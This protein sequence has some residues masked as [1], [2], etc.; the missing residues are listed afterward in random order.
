MIAPAAQRILITDDDANVLESLSQVLL[1]EGYQVV[2]APSAAEALAILRREPIHLLITDMRMPKMNGLDL[3]R[4]VLKE[5][6]NLPV[7]ILTAHGTVREAVESMRIGAV[8]FLMKPLGPEELLVK[9][10]KRLEERAM[11]AEVFRLSAQ[12]RKRGRFADIIGSNARMR[13]IFADIEAVAGRPVVVLIQGEPGTG[14]ELIA[15]AIHRRSIEMKLPDGLSEPELKHLRDVAE[16]KSPYVPVNC[17]ALAR[18][19]LESQLF[20]HKR[21]SF[22]GAIADQEGMFVAAG[23]GTLFLDE[24]TELDL[25]LQVR[26]L[27]ALEEREVIPVGSTRPVRVSARVIT[28]TNQNIQALVQAKRFRSDLYWRINVV[29]V[30]VPPL[31]ERVD[32]IPLLVDYFQ[33][34]FARSYGVAPREVEAPV[35]EAFQSYRWPGNVR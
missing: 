19:L 3:T 8:D 14:K 25:D 35:M 32:D 27:R 34:S 9:V 29:N 4:E 15:R 30:D 16:V 28:A 31:R 26:L 22:T 33:Q 18:N 23:N 11:R 6:P 20:G 13:Q 7:V 24:I 12:V 1:L 5:W 2:T 17:G 21:G 10:S